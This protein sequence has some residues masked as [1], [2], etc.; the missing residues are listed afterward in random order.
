MHA[1]T[2]YLSSPGAKK[3]YAGLI[4]DSQFYILAI[5]DKVMSNRLYPSWEQLD[6]MH[7][8]LT[9]GE[10]ALIRYLDQHLPSDLQ[11][12]DKMPLA[13]Y[14]G[15]LIFAQPY[16]NGTRPDIVILNPSVGMVIYEVKDW[17]LE[18]Y[19]WRNGEF[20]VTTPKGYQVV[21]SPL[22]QARHYRE[23][24]ISQL[25]PEIGEQL[26]REQ[27]QSNQPSFGLIKTAVY[28]H[29]STTL[30]AQIMFAPPKRKDQTDHQASI[31]RAKFFKNEPV[32]GFDS[33]TSSQLSQI[34]PDVARTGSSY[35]QPRWNAEVIF[36]MRPPY[37]SIEQGT[38]LTL[39]GNQYKVAEPRSGHH[40]ARG[41]AGSGKTQAL[42]YRAAKLASQD[43]EVLIITYN[44]TLWHYIHDMIKRAPFAFSMERFTLVHFHGFC[45][46]RLNELGKK[47]PESK[48]YD[49]IQQFFQTGVPNAV[50]QAIN[51]ASEELIKSLPKYSA[52]LIDEGQDYYF[53]W[54]ELLTQYFLDSRDELLVV[55]DKKQNIYERELLWLDKRGNRSGG[56]DKFRENYIDLKTSYRLPQSIAEITNEFSVT[57]NLNQD[58]RAIKSTEQ[59]TLLNTQHIVW[60]N[61]KTFQWLEYIYFAFLRLKHA[62]YHPSDIVILLPSH[63]LGFEAV[64]FFNQKKIQVNH[65]FERE[66]EKGFHPNKKAFWPGDSRLK[67][68]TIHSF[69]GWELKNIVLFIPEHAPESNAQLHSIVYTALTR[70]RENLIVL[71]SNHLYQEF[72]ENL[73]KHWNKQ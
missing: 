47:W 30:T 61:I 8:P 6:K 71:N 10:K 56:L 29:K 55:C 49:D 68:S 19:S 18:L 4:I 38:P 21:K 64:D 28:F 1:G 33:L 69:K 57:F 11:W 43:H 70:T 31:D 5:N 36:W 24:L 72:G 54:Y 58:L 17:D 26:D 62:E 12:N 63:E 45:K 3:G 44:I 65:V 48:G 35:W 7:N 46:D 23:K 16:F 40:R 34:V 73:P 53:E 39:R 25:V 37:H 13:H 67:M 50:I 60:L 2:T 9:P 22:K 14:G 66:D 15:W 52:V 59:L 27:K 51:N 20:C 41:V 42:A 32:F